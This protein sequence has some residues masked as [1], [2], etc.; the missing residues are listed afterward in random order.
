MGRTR[1]VVVG[2]LLVAAVCAARVLSAESLRTAKGFAWMSKRSAHFDYF[3]EAGTL[4]ERDI[5][6]IERSMEKSRAG[7]EQLLGARFEIRNRV[8]LVASRARMKEL[9]GRETNG[10]A[11]GTASAMVY[12]ETIK[13]LGAHETC[14]NFA[15]SLWGKPNEQWIDEGLAVYSDD[16][17]QGHRLHE[18]AKWLLDRNKLIPVNDLISDRRF[19][20]YSDLITYPELGSFVKFVYE[21]YGRDVVK[22][23]WQ[24]GAGGADQACGRTLNQIEGE[25]RSELTRVDAS[26]V[27]YGI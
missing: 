8:F 24:R 20:E 15:R 9:V 19:R 27:Q 17:W 7:L 18:L 21:K 23:L 16:G 10:L 3:F 1:G 22:T 13:A 25:W 2:L 5:E 6:T 11:L 12:G 4:A 26:S 14:H